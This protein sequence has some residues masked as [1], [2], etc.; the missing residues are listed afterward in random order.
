M[1]IDKEIRINVDD[2]PLNKLR[3][4]TEE[5]AKGMVR[6]A[7]EFSTSGTE[8][9]KDIQEQIKLLE[10]RNA[11][12]E[13]YDRNRLQAARQS[14]Q[15]T[16]QDFRQ[17]AGAIQERA[18]EGRL[19]IEL[20]REIIESIRATSKDEIREDRQNVER[21]IRNSR[22]VRQLGPAGD[23]FQNLRETLQMEY[24]TGDAQVPPGDTQDRY[25]RTYDRNQRI[26]RRVESTLNKAA[27]SENEYVFLTSFLEGIPWV[28]QAAATVAARGISNA[29]G[30]ENAALNYAR[31]NMHSRR[32][33]APLAYGRAIGRQVGLSGAQ[34]GYTPSEGLNAVVDFES[35]LKRDIKGQGVVNLMGA[36]RT[37]GLDRNLITQLLGIQRFDRSTSNPIQLFSQFDK[38]ITDTK[39]HLSVLPEIASTFSNAAMQVLSTRGAVDTGSLSRVITNMAQRTGFRGMRLDRLT[40]AMGGLGRSQN[41]VVR[42]LLM[43]SFRET[44]PNAS[45]LD[46]QERMEGGLSAQSRPGLQRFFEVMRERTGGG[47]PLVFALQSALPDLSIKDI[48]DVIKTGGFSK[49]MQRSQIAGEAGFQERGIEFVGPIEKSSKTITSA[50]ELAGD[51]IVEVI[52]ELK[53]KLS[54]ALETIGGKE[55]PAENTKTE[56]EKINEQTSK[57]IY[58]PAWR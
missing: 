10:R 53:G 35:A 50:L 9:V 38:F 21:S 51:V 27:S 57:D 22:T 24:L 48:R 52:E 17:Q 41:P 25:T 20:L 4:Q 34:L 26:R 47:D 7:R 39:S 29:E 23:P 33:M 45:F 31:Y 5:I 16:P 28:G 43:Q 15:V 56:A 49:L 32:G 55:V 19:Q 30:F 14:G 46:I 12:Q 58:Q 11:I 3:R 13:Q 6:S 44:D 40:G 42:A 2:S 36:E 8:V 18:G 37:L 1:A 54:S